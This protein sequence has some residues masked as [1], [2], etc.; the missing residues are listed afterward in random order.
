[1]SVKNISIAVVG[2]IMLGSR[3][4]DKPD[5]DRV[6]KL[7]EHIQA[8]IKD[9]HLILA[10]LECPITSSKIARANKR[11]NL[12]SS[13]D[14]LAVFDHRFVL[15]L[16]NNHI[17]DFGEQGLVDSLE[18]LESR[19]L[20]HAGAGRTLEEAR[21]P[22]VVE[23]EGVK[24]GILC[25]ADPR[26]NPAG[27][28]QPGTCP[29]APEFL[30]ENLREIRDQVDTY[31]VSLHIGMEF[32]AVP[33]PFMQRIA[34]LCLTEGARLV[35]FHH[36]HCLSGWTCNE[37]GLVFWGTGNFLFPYE[38][39]RGYRP[40][41]DSCVWLASLAV[42]GFGVDSVETVPISLDHA[43][44]PSIAEGRRALRIKRTVTRWSS[45]LESGRFLSVWRLLLMLRPA[46]LWVNIV[47]YLAIARREG[48]FGI[49]SSIFSTI[50]T[51]FQQGYHE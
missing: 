17:M 50:R 45:R 30:R 9:A 42:P 22:A 15:S 41:F 46:Y 26:Y 44:F 43:G 35:V 32:I 37:K 5:N 23:V 33:T 47:N 28:T 51:Q 13:S 16:A 19:G 48:F 18:A 36:S 8:P 7:A 39:P 2:D 31:I 38:I 10:N 4:V 1:M 11:Y 29:A 20:V 40:W 34:D 24:I 21:R 12:R 6:A 3:Y 14:T 25:A 49:L 27:P